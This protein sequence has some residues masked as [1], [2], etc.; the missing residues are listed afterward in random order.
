M[1]S[2]E[3]LKITHI[4]D[5][6][7][8]GVDDRMKGVEREIRDARSDVLDAGNK[9]QTINKQLGRASRSLSLQPPLHIPRL[10]PLIEEQVRDQVFLWLS[11][12]DPSHNYKIARDARRNGTAQWFIQGSIY[13]QWK[14]SGSFLWLR[15]KRELFLVFSMRRPPTIPDFYSRFREKCALVC[16][17]STHVALTELTSSIQ[18][19]DHTRY[20][21]P[22]QCWAGLDGLF[23]FLFQGC[24]ETRSS[25]S[26]SVS[27][28]SAFS[29]V[30]SF[31]RYTL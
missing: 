6:Q 8:I 5:G 9:A 27:P 15:G 18:F 25:Q 2:A 24:E 11:P 29:S 21:S 1:A 4:V 22:A 26:A 10:E 3:Q 13:D 7:V 30:R 16:P 31:F 20:H 19:L 17:S 14:S 28:R 12:S 23:L